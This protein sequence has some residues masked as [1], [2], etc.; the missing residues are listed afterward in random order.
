V[1][2]FWREVRHRQEPGRSTFPRAEDRC[3]GYEDRKPFGVLRLLQGRGRGGHGDPAKQG[4][5]P[6]RPLGLRQEHF[7][8]VPQPDA[9]G[10]PRGLRRGVRQ[11]WR[12]GHLHQRH[13][14]GHYKTADW[15]GLPEAEPLLQV[16]LRER[17]L[18]CPDQR[19]QGRHGRAGGTV[20]ET[21]G[22]VGRGQGQ[23]EEERFRPV[24]RTAAAAG[25]RPDTR[26][27]AGGYPDGRA[28]EC[29]GPGLDPEDRGHHGRTQ[30]ALYGGDRDAQHAAGGAHLG[31][32]GLLLHR[33]HGRPG[34]ALGVRRDD[35]DVLCPGPQGDGGLRHWSLRV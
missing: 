33:A 15:D 30:G 19:L 7:F 23:A 18:G 31:L 11:A 26:C 28:S 17:R 1:R 10:H 20:L 6:H 8:A 29:A 35:E 2:G 16:H 34:P 13:G 3:S 25:Y 5:G 21:R 22:P 4:H 24:W 14:P 9:R 32:H 12:P 27:R